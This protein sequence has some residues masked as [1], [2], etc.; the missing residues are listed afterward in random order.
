M[1][2]VDT[3]TPFFETLIANGTLDPPRRHT[4]R[5][6]H[7]IGRATAPRQSSAPPICHAGGV[8]CLQRS[9]AR[10]AV[11]E[12]SRGTTG[13]PGESWLVLEHATRALS[14][15]AERKFSRYWRIIKP[16]GAFVSWQLLRAVRRRA[17]QAMV[18]AP[19]GRQSTKSVR[20]SRAER[21][22]VLPGDELIP[23]PLDSLT[24]AI[25]I[26]AAPM[27]VWPWLAQM[28]AGNRAGWYSYDFLDNGRQPSATSL[29]PGLQRLLVGM[30]FPA[31]PGATDG[32]TLAAFEPG[33]SL[34]L[35]WK[36]PDGVRLVSWAF[37]LEPLDGGSTRLIVR[38][39][40]GPAYRFHGLPWSV[41][42]RLVPFVHF[43][44]QRKQL[45]GIAR[46]AEAAMSHSSAFKTPEGEAAFFAAYDAAMTLWRVSYEEMN[47]PSR[48]GTTHVVVSGPK[49]APPL[50]SLHGYLATLTMWS[51]NIVDFSKDYRV[52]AI[53]V[54][55]QPSK[56]V[57]TEPIRN[58]ADFVCW[59]TA[60]LDALHL[61]RVSLV[62]MSYGGWLA[63]AFA[64]VA[65]E[66]VQKLVLLSPAA[67]LL[68]LV[69]QFSVR[70]ILMSLFPS[71]LT[72]NWF[73]RWVGI[74]ERSGDADAQPVL[75]LTPV[76]RF[77]AFSNA[78]RNIACRA[79]GVR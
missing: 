69:T 62:G 44:M 6:D 17:E 61:D 75:G 63:L 64:T 30:V 8:R 68:P 55:G 28:G 33:R 60:I 4:A 31:L 38:A 24:H 49:D 74:K 16:L 14:P 9:G 59:L 71:R 20:A 48:F 77:E 5:S 37:V 78:A 7:G 34:V 18:R 70:G 10:E 79:H 76:S 32:F 65:A 13:R 29:I 51:P 46:R 45:L 19:C 15:N 39:R 56:S 54:M 40:G 66:R 27:D 57:P 53:D 43:M 3:R 11:H 35:D 67:S 58:A 36:T 42:K 41:T 72:V 23:T 12:R 21:T 26:R 1:P 73:A 47:V 52:Y 22:R 25:T 50:V 2:A